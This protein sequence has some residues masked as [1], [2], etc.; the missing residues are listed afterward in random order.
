MSTNHLKQLGIDPPDWLFPP[1]TGDLEEHAREV[2]TRLEQG[3]D[4]ILDSGTIRVILDV[5]YVIESERAY[6]EQGFDRQ[7]RL[8]KWMNAIKRIQRKALQTAMEHIHFAGC[9]PIEMP[10]KGKKTKARRRDDATRNDP[11]VLD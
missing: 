6:E 2:L 4:G 3:F 8:N 1:A 11:H 5:V 10:V 7:T 9:P